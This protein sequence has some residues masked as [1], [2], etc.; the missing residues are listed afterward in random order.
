LIFDAVDFAQKKMLPI[1]G[2]KAIVVLSD[3]IGTPKTASAKSTLLNA[4]EQEVV[5]FQP[6]SEPVTIF[7]LIDLSGSVRRDVTAIATTANSFVRQLRPK[8]TIGAATFAYRVYPM[9]DFVKIGDIRGPANMDTHLNDPDTLIFDAV[10]FA[11][12]KMLPIKGRKAIVV[13]SDGIGTPKT[14][15]AKSTLLNAVEQEALIYTIQFNSI[16]RGFTGDPKK[17]M[18]VLVDAALYLDGLANATGGRHFLIEQML[19]DL[20]SS[21]SQ[22][23]DELT[24]QYTLGYEPSRPGQDGEKR[25]ISVKVNQPN[26][27]VRARSEVVYKKPGK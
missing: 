4:V 21:L 6:T 26:L 7:L 16:G 2:R 9:M 22:I 1:K 19:P 13:L 15:S 27:A 17:I 3:S 11:Q 12:K 18:K 23:A 24:Q 10:D 8:D 5:Y 20:R 25:Q 14:A